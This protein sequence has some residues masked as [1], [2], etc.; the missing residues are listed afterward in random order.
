MNLLSTTPAVLVLED[1]R[2]VERGTHAALL[3]G[4]G[5]YAA[6]WRRQQEAANAEEG[7]I[8]AQGPQVCDRIRHQSVVSPP[9][10]RKL[11]MANTRMTTSSSRDTAAA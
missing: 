10:R 5:K 2:V 4:N 11:R 1:G 9:E 8:H 6:M 3:A 7:R